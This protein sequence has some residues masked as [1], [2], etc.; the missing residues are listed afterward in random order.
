MK[1]AVEILAP[2]PNLQLIWAIPR[3]LLNIFQ[4]AS[5]IAP[6][7]SATPVSRR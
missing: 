4:A 2:H 7:S 3:E 5:G 1:Q 6:A